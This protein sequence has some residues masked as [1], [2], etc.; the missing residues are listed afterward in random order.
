MSAVPLVIS[1]KEENIRIIEENAKKHKLT[2]EKYIEKLVDSTIDRIHFIDGYSYNFRNN[3]LEFKNLKIKLTK[4]EHSFFKYLLNNSDR[5]V[6]LDEL[7]KNVWNDDNTTIYTIRNIPNK[8]RIKT[9]K[10]LIINKFG[11]GYRLNII[12]IFNSEI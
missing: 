6:S 10:E 12:N 4:K 5:Y 9:C 3:S 11:W 8:I 1:I 2:I 7:A